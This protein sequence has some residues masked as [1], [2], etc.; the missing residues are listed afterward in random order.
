MLTITPTAITP[1]AITPTAITPTAIMPTAI[2]PTADAT[3]RYVARF[4]LLAAL[5]ATGSAAAQDDVNPSDPTRLALEDYLRRQYSPFQETTMVDDQGVREDRI[6]R[7][8][9]RWEDT[10]RQHFDAYRFHTPLNGFRCKGYFVNEHKRIATFTY[11]RD[12]RTYRVVSKDSPD[13]AVVTVWGASR[14]SSE[15]RA[16]QNR[17]RR[18][19]RPFH[20]GVAPAPARAYGL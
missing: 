3:R 18:Q 10:I 5:M 7:T 9:A 14:V 13:G 4:L 20:P 16:M 19:Q 12:G 11:D 6:F 17:G 2:M 15:I 1:T 8:R